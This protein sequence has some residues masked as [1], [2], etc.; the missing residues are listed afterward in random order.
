MPIIRTS[1]SE[2]SSGSARQVEYQAE[3]SSAAMLNL[4]QAG[5][6]RLAW[7]GW[8]SACA[9]EAK[10]PHM[11]AASMTAAKAS[12]LFWDVQPIDD[13]QPVNT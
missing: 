4:G 11:A 3:G 2:P 13:A 5:L 8:A 7:A 6:G 12:G 9:G 1:E 10:T